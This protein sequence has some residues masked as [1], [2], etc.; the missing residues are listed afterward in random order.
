MKEK[1]AHVFLGISESLEKL[2]QSTR[3]QYIDDDDFKSWFEESFK[4]H[5]YNEDF[6]DVFHSN[7]LIKL[8]ESIEN[9]EYYNASSL[10]EKI[11]YDFKNS[12]YVHIPINS[13]VI[14]LKEYCDYDKEVLTIQADSILLFYL[15]EYQLIF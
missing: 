5:Y 3:C 8:Q 13:A 14:V 2:N 6:R 12:K 1:D 10:S 11:M 4:I 9:L 7:S 15:G